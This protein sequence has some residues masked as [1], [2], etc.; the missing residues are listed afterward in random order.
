MFD[1]RASHERVS[2]MNGAFFN[3]S[4]IDPNE[5][6]RI[7]FVWCRDKDAD[8]YVLLGSGHPVSAVGCA[9]PPGITVGQFSITFPLPPGCSAGN[10]VV[11][12][13][14]NGKEPLPDVTVTSCSDRGGDWYSFIQQ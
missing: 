9:P 6:A 7:V 8:D 12:G 4:G 3:V 11:T 13:G 5:G 14:K 10:I 1:Y 2:D